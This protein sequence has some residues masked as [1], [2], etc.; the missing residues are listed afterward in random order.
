MSQAPLMRIPGNT[1]Q[2]E[3]LEVLVKE[4]KGWRGYPQGRTREC[5]PAIMTLLQAAASP[6]GFCLLDCS[7]L[8]GLSSH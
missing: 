7:S 3:L 2:S 1:G 8:Q 6:S 4:W 5:L